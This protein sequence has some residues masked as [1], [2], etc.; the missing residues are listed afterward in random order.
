MARPRTPSNVL[1]MRGA[2]KKDPKRARNDEP[3]PEG[4]IGPCPG[5]FGQ[6]QIEAWE[7]I[8]ETCHLGVLCRADRLAVE[9]AAVLLAGF[10]K[11]PDEVKSSDRSMY[12]TLLGR[13]GMTPADRSKVVAPKKPAVNPFAA[14][15][16]KGK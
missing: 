9:Q 7:N 11:N 12:L 8:V 5:Y 16:K 15:V 10:R 3:A 1:E 13:F 6:D 4:D 14:L 2:Y